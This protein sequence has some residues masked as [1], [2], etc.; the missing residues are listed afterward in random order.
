MLIIKPHPCTLERTLN[1]PTYIYSAWT[2]TGNP[3][4]AY[5]TVVRYEI[6]GAWYD[7]RCRC[8]HTAQTYRSPI[9]SSYY[10]TYVGPASTTTGYTWTTNLRQSNATAWSSGAAVVQGQTV[11]D[12]ADLNDYL[13][14]VAISGASNT[15]RPSEAIRSPN[16]TIAAYWLQQGKS[17]AWAW[18][19]YEI[20]TRTEGYD[21]NGAL[22]NPV[23]TVDAGTL[24]FPV[25][26]IAFAGL[27]NV[28]SISI[29]RYVN[30][31]NVG[32]STSTLTVSSTTS[33]SYLQDSKTVAFAQVDAGNSLKLSVTLTRS[34]QTKPASVGVIVIGQGFTLASTEWDVETSVL[35]FS[36]R[37]RNADFGTIKFIPR[38][39]AK[40]LRATG[41]LDSTTSSGD[42]LLRLLSQLSGAPIFFDL[43]EGST[44]YDRLRIFG[45]CTRAS[46]IIKAVG[47]ESVSLDM[48]GLAE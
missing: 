15:L 29:T 26:Y 1:T 25:N 13:A 35:N 22:I 44:N 39:S 46:S 45:I 48:E 12:A 40:T 43:N 30:S 8:G 32:G 24:G 19:D 14:T 23:F 5:K 2:A 27:I 17:N 6:N 37:E 9:N 42:F 38:G 33:G 10:W 20:M 3:Y 34:D 7:Y 4:Y 47:W 16:A 28:A 18:N 11:F 41:Y 31:N 21:V 36:R